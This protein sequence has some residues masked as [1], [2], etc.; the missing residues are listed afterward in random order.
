MKP[1]ST[2]AAVIAAHFSLFSS[3]FSQSIHQEEL[4]RYNATGKTMA[5]DYE[6][7]VAREALPEDKLDCQLDYT[8]YGWHPYWMGSAYTNYRWDLLSHLCFFS[9]E[10]D[11]ASG[12]PI[13]THGW[14]TSAAVNT[15]L[16]QGVKVTLCVTL[17]SGH[18]TF[19]TNA[20]SKQNLI[21]QLITLISA[22]GANGVNI[23][24]EGIPSSQATN[25]A[26]FMVDL[27]NQMHAAIPGSEVSTVLY[28]VDWNSVFNF[29]IMEPEVDQYVVMGYDYYYTNSATAGPEDPLYH[30]G[31]SYNYTLSRTITDYLHDGCPA[32][33]LV[34]GLPY[35]GREWSTTSLAIP[36][37][38]TA[39][40]VARTYSTVR[41]NASG[42]YSTA[43]HTYRSD[44][45]SDQYGFLSGGIPK[46]CF[47]TKETA[48][49]ERL[50]HI[51][52]SGIAGIGIWALGYDGGYDAMWNTIED[53]LTDCY[54]E[55]CA[56]F[57]HDF[58]GPEKNYYNDESYTWTLAPSGASSIAVNFSSFDVESGY[59]YLYI[60]D[61][62]SVSSPQISGSPFT[63]TNSPGNFISSTGSLT[64]R[65][66]SDLSTTKPGFNATY[67]CQQGPPVAGFTVQ[68]LNVCEGDSVL[69]MS[70]SLNASAFAWT[71]NDGT[72][73]NAAAAETWFTPQ[74]NGV[75][76]ISLAASNSFGSNQLSQNLNFLILPNATADFT[77]STYFS[78]LPNAL[79][80]FTNSSTNADSYLW[81]FGDGTQSTVQSPGHQF[82]TSGV[83]PVSLVAESQ[84]CK[85]DTLIQ[86]ITVGFLALTE[87]DSAVEVYPVPFNDELYVKGIIP[88]WCSII[89]AS[90]RIVFET[91][92]IEDGHI[93]GLGAVPAG[94]YFLV[95][96]KDAERWSVRIY[97]D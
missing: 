23:D 67:Q 51:R 97:K 27:A 37:G 63:G 21:T 78:T 3:V 17:F 82:T 57:I 33:K 66:T 6:K 80:Q 24:F 43:N 14:S 30:F 31:T 56:G 95:V 84:Q 34:M 58:G 83:Y 94:I 25:F 39:A 85:N 75:C 16:V 88:D 45:R 38:T 28:A 4:E 52:R 7:K 18:S 93:S 20:T 73:S 92:C 48:F 49:A 55:P 40:G 70:N 42:N 2:L 46:Q 29:S 26:N 90:G 64:F 11:A 5:S 15:A 13:S 50:A 62:P 1:H 87:A 9:Y 81:N 35:Y 96:G 61:G 86:E 76:T 12:N 68:S 71:S 36:S 60:Y 89:D 91:N 69:L 47:I 53:Y 79:V 22:R 54:V 10:V 59:D 19:L 8:V 65:F 72:F 77:P 32:E 44:C 41:S 74:M